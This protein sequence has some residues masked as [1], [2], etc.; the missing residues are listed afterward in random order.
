M[1]NHLNMGPSDLIFCETIYELPWV[2]VMLIG[3]ISD[4][5]PIMG[6]RR[7]SYIIIMGLFH[8]FTAF[9]IFF[10]YH[11]YSITVLLLTL[12]TLSSAFIDV[13]FEALLV[14]Q[15]RRDPEFGSQ[16]LLSF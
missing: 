5:V 14:I 3:F 6:T 1:K 8:F 7:K 15:S 2:F 10:M 9:G 4:N 13:A 12:T 16:Q 11:R